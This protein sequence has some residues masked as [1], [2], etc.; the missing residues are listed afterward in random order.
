MA[1]KTVNV[2][3]LVDAGNHMLKV[4]PAG[5][6]EFRMGVIAMMERVMMD[7]N[8]YGGYRSLL[9][10]E[11]K[12]GYPGVR[13]HNTPRLQNGVDTWFVNVDDSRRQYC[14]KKY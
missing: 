7:A 2:S 11:V 8:N 14:L 3:E 4:T 1:R 13:C 10:D 6:T 9:E 12:D 5:A